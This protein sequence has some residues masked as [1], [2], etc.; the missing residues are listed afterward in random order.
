MN[1]PRAD[2]N[3]SSADMLKTLISRLRLFMTV[4]LHP[5]SDRDAGRTARLRPGRAFL[6]VGHPIDTIS[7]SLPIRTTSPAPS[8]W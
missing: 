2:A 3:R 5:C 6:R 1:A 4:G 7:S 8:G